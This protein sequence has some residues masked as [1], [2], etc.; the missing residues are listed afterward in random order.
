MSQCFSQGQHSVLCLLFASIPAA[1]LEAKKGLQRYIPVR[2]AVTKLHEYISTYFCR[3]LKGIHGNS[4]STQSAQSLVPKE[5][6]HDLRRQWRHCSGWPVPKSGGGS[7]DHYVEIL[8]RLFG[9][10]SKLWYQR[11]T[12]M[13]MFS[14]RPIHFGG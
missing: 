6:D 14:R 1:P 2:L 12:E 7:L 5:P 9:N 11:P 8:W 13:I 4:P 3:Y 10:G